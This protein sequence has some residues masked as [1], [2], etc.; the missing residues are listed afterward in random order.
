MNVNDKE[1]VHEWFQAFESHS[2]TTM[3][4]TKGYSIK[5][6]RFLFRRND[7]AFIAMKLKKS[8]MIMKPSIYAQNILCNASIDLCLEN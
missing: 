3:A 5:G 4:Q 6:K 8:K 1:R 7:I 2:K